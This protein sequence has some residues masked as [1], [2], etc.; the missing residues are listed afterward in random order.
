MHA[1]TALLA[2]LLAAFAATPAHALSIHIA[3]TSKSEILSVYLAGL[4]EDGHKMSMLNFMQSRPGETVDGGSETLKHL[5]SLALDYG[6]GRLVLKDASPLKDKEEIRLVLSFDEHGQPALATDGGEKLAIETTDLRF[7]QDA[8]GAVDAAELA[9]AA[10]RG[11]V[12]RLAKD[13]PGVVNDPVTGDCILPVRA[14]GAVWT[15][16]ASFS[17]GSSEERAL[18]RLRLMQEAGDSGL[19]NLEGVIESFIESMPLHPMS[20]RSSSAVLAFCGPAARQPL[21]AEVARVRFAEMV[22]DKGLFSDPSKPADLE[23]LLVGG[24]AYDQCVKASGKK[25]DAKPQAK[26][27]EGGDSA[28]GEAPAAQ[29]EQPEQPKPAAGGEQQ[30]KEPGALV[31]RTNASLVILEL[32]K[33][34]SKQ[35]KKELESQ[36]ADTPA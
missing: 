20:V 19:N 24:K 26:A 36:A 22:A 8:P 16:V 21:E 11:D 25:E 27:G 33:D 7:A 29:P 15:G 18:A 35:V 31:R 5:E 3:N 1:H 28:G 4:T 10:T 23:G 32:L 14:G 6:R 17:Y 12:H 34:S 30:E 13:T 9:K 2:L